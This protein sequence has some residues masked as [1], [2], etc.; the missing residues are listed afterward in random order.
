M[1][2]RHQYK[3]YQQ[4]LSF[5]NF[6]TCDIPEKNIM[7][8]YNEVNQMVLEADYHVLLPCKFT[9][10]HLNSIEQQALSIISMGVN[11]GDIGII[12]LCLFNFTM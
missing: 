2:T 9:L 12:L 1:I 4:P 3:F 5:L 6:N 10:M 11:V 8:E 7:L